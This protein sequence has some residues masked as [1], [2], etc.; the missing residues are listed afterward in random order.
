MTDWIQ[1]DICRCG[2]KHR[3]YHTYKNCRSHKGQTHDQSIVDI[4]GNPVLV[5]S[6]LARVIQELNKLGLRTK[7]SC[8]GHPE[9]EEAYLTFDK[10]HLEGYDDNKKQDQ[11]TIRWYIPEVEP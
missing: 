11:F 3:D 2:V 10:L 4:D 9:H 7:W 8:H 1:G 5:D 6:K